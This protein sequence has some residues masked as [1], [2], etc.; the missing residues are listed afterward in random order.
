MISVVTEIVPLEGT[1][2]YCGSCGLDHPDLT[3]QPIA[4]LGNKSALVAWC[5][6]V[7]P[8]SELEGRHQNEDILVPVRHQPRVPVMVMK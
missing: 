8:L 7:P 3:G 5:K 6:R 4:Y 1:D 2:P